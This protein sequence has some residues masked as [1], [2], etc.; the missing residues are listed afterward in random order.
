MAEAAAA[1]INQLNAEVVALQQNLQNLQQQNN[2]MGAQI[3]QLQQQPPPQQPRRPTGQKLNQFSNEEGSDDWLVFKR[4][5]Q[6]Y[7]QLNGYNDQEQRLALAG[8]M[9]GKAALATLDIDVTA[10]INNVPPTINAV[11]QLYEARFLPAAASQLSRVRFDQAR[12]GTSE[13]ILD[14]HSRLRSLYN[15]AY[16]NNADDTLLIRRFVMGLR[17]KELRMQAMRDR[18]ATYAAALV[19]A[20]NESSVLQLVKVTELGAAP[21]GEEPMEIGA[22]NQARRPQ[23]PPQNQVKGTC[24]FC[25]QTG[26]WKRNCN[27]LKK[28]Q[29]FPKDKAGSNKGRQGNKGNWQQQRQQLIA[30]LTSVLEDEEEDGDGAPAQEGHGE[31]PEGAGQDF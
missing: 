30:A 2:Q 31:G 4:H 24:H 8:C 28:A 13:S 18:P 29:K 3:Q 7:A 20:Q 15:Q 17:K 14:Y 12:Q 27:L 19:S 6:A 11:I 21:A 26:H 10:N 9:V 23:P 25:G 1:Q 16:P 22:I 5:F